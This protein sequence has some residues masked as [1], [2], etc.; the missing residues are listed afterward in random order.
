MSI[1]KGYVLFMLSV[2]ISFTASAQYTQ[3]EGGVESKMGY[4]RYVGLGA[5][6]TY[7]VMKDEAIS[8]LVFSQ[9]SA[10]PMLTHTK[11]SNTIYSQL[12]LKASIV[13]LEHMDYKI[14]RPARVKTQRANLDY[15]FLVKMPVEMRYLDIRAGGLV[16]GMFSYKKAPFKVDAANVY[17]YAASVGLCGRVT[18]EFVMRDHTTFLSWDVG[19]PFL[20]N[21]SRPYYLNRVENAN[22]DN[23]P[24]QNFLGNSVTG[25]VGK[26]FRLN[27]RVAWMYRLENGNLIQI[28]YQW[29]YSRMKSIN[30]AYFVEHIL[31]L[32]FM[33]NY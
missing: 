5:G 24:I 8:R 23:K 27:S 12:Q 6:A 16:S 14:S 30:K 19:I 17:E 11:V 7:Q 28:S 26:Y 4:L 20:A 2:L 32:I 29:D 21:F 18:R 31:S 9:V 10:L 15:R 33:F 3:D 1:R 22:P 25:T 13:N